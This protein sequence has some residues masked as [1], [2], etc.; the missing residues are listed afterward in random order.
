MKIIFQII[1][2]L[3]GSVFNCSVSLHVESVLDVKTT[4]QTSAR[5]KK[6][7][8]RVRELQTVVRLM[9]PGELNR[10]AISEATKA[11]GKS[12]AWRDTLARPHDSRRDC[13]SKFCNFL[14]GSF[15]AVSK[16]K[17]AKKWRGPLLI[18]NF[19]PS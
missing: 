18:A 5:K 8:P 4:R 15:S 19:P 10:H 9:L 6:N 3:F 11:V 2:Q 16:P 7:P 1:K 12:A 13:S 14:V 17:F